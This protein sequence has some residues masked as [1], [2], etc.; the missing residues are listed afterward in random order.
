MSLYKRSAC[1]PPYQLTSGHLCWLVLSQ[2]EITGSHF[3]RGSLS[4]E[5][6]L[7]TRLAFEQACGAF[8]WLRAQYTVGRA[9]WE[10]VVLGS[11]AQQ[12][13]R[14]KP[15]SCIPP[16]PLLQFLPPVSFPARVPAL[17]SLSD[18]L[19][20]GCIIKLNLFLT[21]LLLVMM[22]YHNRRKQTKTPF[23]W[24]RTRM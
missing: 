14:S 10:L 15:G 12:A 11:E 5:M 21:K 22:F 7:L 6:V 8:S 2:Q 24:L 19:L 16:S 18:G 9:T 17:T 20:P 3:G 13:I 4:W 23:P 1:P